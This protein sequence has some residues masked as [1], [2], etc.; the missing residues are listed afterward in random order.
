M[1][2]IAINLDVAQGEDRDEEIESSGEIRISYR[3]FNS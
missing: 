3:A 2:S 1:I